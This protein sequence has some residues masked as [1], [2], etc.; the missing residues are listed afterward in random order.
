[1]LC[2]FQATGCDQLCPFSTDP[3]D[4]L[5][6]EKPTVKSL[7]PPTPFPARSS[8]GLPQLQAKVQRD[9]RSAR[10]VPFHKNIHRARAC[11]RVALTQD[12]P[13]GGW[14]LRGPWSIPDG[15]ERGP[16]PFFLFSF[17]SFGLAKPKRRLGP[18]AGLLVWLGAGV[19]S[20]WK[21]L[22]S[23]CVLERLLLLGEGESSASAG[24]CLDRD[25]LSCLEG[26]SPGTGREGVLVILACWIES[27]TRVGVREKA[28][29]T[30]NKQG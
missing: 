19:P 29:S 23:L 1:M 9:S 4:H 22:F 6:V 2:H 7:S 20:K 27:C 11:A 13:R 3:S 5:G 14:G 17:F 25:E 21:E 18:S 30:V 24:P 28:N 10:G 8:Q 26:E 15:W 12:K 16:F